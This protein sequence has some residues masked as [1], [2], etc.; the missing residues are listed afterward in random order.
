MTYHRVCNLINTT[1]ATSAA[2][3]EYSSG[4]LSSPPVFSV[5][6]VTQSL[7]V[8]VCRSLFVPLSFFFWQLSCLLFF[9]LDSDYSFGIFKL[10]LHVYYSLTSRI[11]CVKVS[12]LASSAVDCGVKHCWIKLKTIK[13]VFVASLHN[14]RIKK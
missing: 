13:L 2:G 1:G 9:D 12:V 10:F 7:V 8:C 6:P 4:H 11:G 3:T 14:R 5:V